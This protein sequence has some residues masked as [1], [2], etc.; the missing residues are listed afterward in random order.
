MSKRK[1]TRIGE[2]P[3]KYQCT[4]R[5]CKWEG[6]DKEKTLK[7]INGNQKVHCCPKCGNDEFYGIL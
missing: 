7:P 2:T 1:F 3:A 4:K 6:F 5:K